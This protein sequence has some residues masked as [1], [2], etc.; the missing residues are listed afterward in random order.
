MAISKKIDTIVFFLIITLAILIGYNG[1]YKGNLN[2]IELVKTQINKEKKKNEILTK[3]FFLN[4][5]LKKYQKRSFPEIEITRLIDKISEL[6]EKV[7]IEITNFNPKPSI[8]RGQ[9]IEL[10]LEIPMRCEYHQLGKLLSLIESNQEFI[11][12]NRLVAEKS[13][14]SGQ[15]ESVSLKIVL[16]VNGLYL[17]R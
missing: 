1:I 3:I 9:Y 5:R 11:R 7:G 12:I 14:I 8:N 13:V 4:N 15:K 17:K 2:K 6:A 16:T 10:P